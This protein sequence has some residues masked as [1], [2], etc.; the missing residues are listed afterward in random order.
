MFLQH[1]VHQTMV[2][3]AWRALPV[4]VTKLTGDSWDLD[5]TARG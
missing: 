1:V 4:P 3:L 2:G 5:T